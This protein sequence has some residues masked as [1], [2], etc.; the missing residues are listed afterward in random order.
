MKSVLLGGLK[1]YLVNDGG[2]PLSAPGGRAKF[3]TAGTST[4]ETVYADID[5]TPSMALGPV[6]YT[7]MLGYLPPIWLKTDRLYK[8]VVEQKVS[9]NP[10]QWAVLWEVDNVGYI[11]PHE[12]ED[13]GEAPIFVTNISA[14]KDVDYTAH[15]NVYV[16]GY[17]APGDWGEPSLFTWDGECTKTPEDGAYVLPNGRQ[18]PQAGRW[19]QVFNGYILDVRKFGAIPD[20]LDH[21]DVTVQVVNAVNYSQDNSTRVRP[22]TVCF[23]APGKYG[24]SG[25]FDFSQY[26]FTDIS[27]E[28]NDVYPVEWF[29]G[30]DVVFRNITE[31][32]ATYTLSSSTD[33]VTDRTMVEGLVALVVQGNGRIKVDPAWWG[34]RT[35]EVEDCFVEC[36]RLTTNY[37]NFNRCHVESNGAMGGH[38]TLSNMDFRESWLQYGFDLG[39][40]SLTNVNYSVHD[41]WSGDSYIAIKNSQSDPIY[42]DLGGAIITNA[43]IQSAN[44]KL[45]NCTGSIII[46]GSGYTAL[47]LVDFVG[48]VVTPATPS[49][50]PPGINAEDCSITFS[51][52][53][54]FATMTLRRC[55]T[56]GSTAVKAAGKTTI[57]GSFTV[58]AFTIG[59]DVDIRRS[60][61][62]G[63][64]SHSQGGTLKLVLVDNVISA[65]YTIG[66]TSAGTL[67][68]AIIT[69]NYG[70]VQ[71]PVTIDRTNLDA[72][73]SHHT[74]S[75]N[76]NTGTFI[77]D[78]CKSSFT[79]TVK[80][81]SVNQPES[82]HVF[83]R[84]SVGVSAGTLG[85]YNETSDFDTVKFF[86]IGTDAFT[87]KASLMCNLS[88]MKTDNGQTQAGDQNSVNYHDAYLAAVHSGGD[89]FGL[90]AHGAYTS[91]FLWG[92][93]TWNLGDTLPDD[94]TIDV[95]IIYENMESHQ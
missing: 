7:D 59:G 79:A 55:E 57:D 69:G 32:S 65:T 74:Y 71:N 49:P 36:H 18:Q 93:Y 91:S 50:T 52:G 70:S 23:L 40:L 15:T 26:T 94:Y 51:G 5:L 6:V 3:F 31:V 56:D 85:I 89:D 67:V 46:S 43:Q 66:G 77:P 75:Y 88:T 14:L 17:Y 63:A 44:V 25:N 87:V 72:V 54:D 34:S 82:A 47:N 20:L 45:A 27:S 76:G 10:D 39:N 84:Q 58:N 78:A 38:V 11:D 33:V 21:P 80:Y 92:L 37:K 30:A 12:S 61:V 29:I 22:L 1:E 9:D 4:P 62:A 68:N 8:V 53:N 2:H 95:T 16:L 48:T 42:G 73:D 24:F 64:I 28:S 60:N 86:R 41:C 83:G 35:C 19:K 81:Y 13:P 90:R